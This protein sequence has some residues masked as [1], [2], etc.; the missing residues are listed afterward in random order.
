MTKSGLQDVLESIH[1]YAPNAVTHM[2]SGKA[3]HCAIRGH[4]LVDNALTILL[5]E[6]SIES[7]LKAHIEE[8]SPPGTVRFQTSEQF[9]N[10]EVLT[11]YEQILNYKEMQDLACKYET[12][13]KDN[14]FCQMFNNC[15]SLSHLQNIMEIEKLKLSKNRTARL[16]FLYMAMV[17]IL[18]QFIRSGLECSSGC[19]N[20]KGISCSNSPTFTDLHVFSGLKMKRK[21]CLF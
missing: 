21:L 9:E 2:L 17:N 12:L 11:W 18:Q 1:V 16:W 4:M 13:K 19:G 3:F 10:E 7:N 8:T 15:E 14:E 20:C 6:E 5:L